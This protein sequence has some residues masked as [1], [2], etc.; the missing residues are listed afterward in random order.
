MK[1]LILATIL[2]TSTIIAND[3]DIEITNLLNTNGKLRIALYNNEKN[4]KEKNNQFKKIV[5]DIN[6]KIVKYEFKDI[7]TGT[8]TIAVFHDENSNEKLD[9]NFLGIPN[10]SY[11]FSNNARGIFGPPSFEESKFELNKNSKVSIKIK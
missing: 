9:K 6:S 2:T 1:K 4:Y 8:Y 11:G 7:P 3:I 5:L 10:E